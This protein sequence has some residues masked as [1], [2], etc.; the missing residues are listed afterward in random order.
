MLNYIYITAI[1]PKG[2]DP[3]S[4]FMYYQIQFANFFIRIFHIY[5]F[6]RDWP[7]FSFTLLVR[8]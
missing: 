4:A 1:T 2:C 8:F 7:D 3:L 5:I 6:E